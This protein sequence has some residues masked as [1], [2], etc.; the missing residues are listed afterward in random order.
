MEMRVIMATQIRLP[1]HSIAFASAFLVSIVG[2][3]GTAGTA[4]AA[5][6]AAAPGPSA[7]PDSHWYYRTDRTTQRKCWY[8]RSASLS[9]E[10]VKPT[11]S[12]S[13]ATTYSLGSFK[14]FMAQRG[15]ANLSDKDVEQLYAEFLEWRR[16][17]EN[18]ARLHQ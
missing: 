16:R 11:Q 14:D 7:P 6:C 1:V 3:I 12:A 8:L 5:D 18:S 9:Q 10:A 4:R 17:P 2:V 13:A 15:N